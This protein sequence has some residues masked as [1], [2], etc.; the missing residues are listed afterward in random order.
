M[1]RLT[2][3]AFWLGIAWSVQVHGAASSGGKPGSLRSTKPVVRAAPMVQVELSP[4]QML[5]ADKVILGRIPCELGVYV[6]IGRDAQLAG[7]FVLE[8]GR[9]KHQM[10]PMPTSTGAVRLEDAGSGAVWLQLSNKSMLMN[11][12]RGQRMADDCMNTD[13]IRVAQALLNNP[14]P[15]LLDATALETVGLSDETNRTSNAILPVTK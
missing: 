12:K 4:E 13:Q 8:T 5:V 11:Q 3:F 6:T 10:T 14:A 9:E 15:H 7:R 2:L 1:K